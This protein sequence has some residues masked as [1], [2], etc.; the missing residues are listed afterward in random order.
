MLQ[1]HEE[2]VP[3]WSKN[4]SKPLSCLSLTRQLPA[5]YEGWGASWHEEKMVLLYQGQERRRDYQLLWQN[6]E[7]SLPPT[8]TPAN[9]E[10][11]NLLSLDASHTQTRGQGLTQNPKAEPE[12]VLNKWISKNSGE[13]LSQFEQLFWAKAANYCNCIKDLHVVALDHL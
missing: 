12:Q 7:P 8:L 4:H 9:L 6:Y 5:N 1:A 13:E 3:V 11:L 2:A 10:R